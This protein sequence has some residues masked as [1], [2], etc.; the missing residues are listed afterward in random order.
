M[1]IGSNNNR[2]NFNGQKPSFTS[3]FD[4]RFGIIQEEAKKNNPVINSNQ[5]SHIMQ[6]S[7]ITSKSEMNERSFTMLQER[8]NNGLISLEEFTK[9]CNMLNKRK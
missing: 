7:N 1:I 2:N 8:Y 5:T 9:K 6:H 4:Q 3:N